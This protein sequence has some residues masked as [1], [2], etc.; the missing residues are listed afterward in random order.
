MTKRLKERSGLGYKASKILVIWGLP[1]PVSRKTSE[2]GVKKPSCLSNPSPYS[3]RA[4]WRRASLDGFS[5]LSIVFRAKRP[6][7]DGFTFLPTFC[8]KT[9]SRSGFKG[10]KPLL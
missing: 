2:G 4:G 1:R 3:Y 8:V 9:K 5:H 10:R 6:S 7:A